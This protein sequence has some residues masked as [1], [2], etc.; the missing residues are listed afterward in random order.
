MSK[1]APFRKCIKENE[2]DD[3]MKKQTV[4]NIKHE[5]KKSVVLYVHGKGGTAEEAEHYYDLCHISFRRLSIW[6][7]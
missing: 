2:A 1:Y 7:N 4:E 5:Q 6:R 3:S